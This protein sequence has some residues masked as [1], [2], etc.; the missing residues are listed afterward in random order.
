MCLCFLCALFMESLSSSC[1]I[2][3]QS[4]SQSRFK[5]CCC[6]F[7]FSKWHFNK[8]SRVS[9]CLPMTDT[10]EAD[11]AHGPLSVSWID[12]ENCQEPDCT[13]LEPL[14]RKG[15]SGGVTVTGN[16]FDEN[17]LELVEFQMLLWF[18]SLTH[19]RFLPWKYIMNK[20]HSTAPESSD[21]IHFSGCAFFLGQMHFCFT[22]FCESW[23]SD[24]MWIWICTSLS[25]TRFIWSSEDNRSGVLNIEWSQS[26]S[27]SL[28]FKMEKYEF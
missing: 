25:W 11:G 9:I 21:I 20:L 6:V 19:P 10:W 17:D 15:C 12:E 4:L 16:N 22:S 27:P 26:Q 14:G 3:S 24:R 23:S 18:F 1:S 8:L 5:G 7:F 28:R 13:G 2:W